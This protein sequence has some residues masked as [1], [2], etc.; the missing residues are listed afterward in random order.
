MKR[1][2]SLLSI[3]LLVSLA[4]CVSAIAGPKV[5][6]V[7]SDDH[8]LVGEDYSLDYAFY[9]PGYDDQFGKENI[10]IINSIAQWG[11]ESEAAIE[12]MVRKAI[13]LAGGF[14]VKKGD[15]VFIKP[16]L[17]EDI[18]VIVQWGWQNGKPATPKDIQCETTD[19]RVVRGVAIA[20]LEKGAK[21]VMFGELPARG[22]GYVSAMHYGYKKMADQL[23]KKY[24][25]RVELVDLKAG[26][27]K[28]YKPKG[29]GG[30]ALKEYAIPE[31]LVNSDVVIS[32]PAMK[33]H[34]MAGVTLSLK[35]IG[36]GAAATNVYGQFKM[37][38]PHQRLAE[39]IVDVCDIVGIDYV[40]V[41]GI[42]AMESTGPILWTGGKPIA[43][44]LVVAGKDPVAVDYITTELMGMQGE[45]IGSTRLAQ[46]YK[47]G[48]FKNVKVVGTPIKVAMKHFEP[49][50]RGGRF[51]GYYA[52]NVGWGPGKP[53]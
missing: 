11:P 45:L 33:T 22:D 27:Y 1:S 28:F 50:P 9:H 48:T 3:V 12:K 51:P 39:V 37:G 52:H 8:K 10:E 4:F 49:V 2:F 24:P 31:I 16:N 53:E 29:T 23:N 42:W 40:V 34:L 38:L 25:G 35:N 47:L 32:V 7:K 17:V 20:A 46:K 14:P 15:T 26:P 43:M 36:I 30:L 41:D 18:M 44:D 19:P 5:A 21:K 13:N 6:V